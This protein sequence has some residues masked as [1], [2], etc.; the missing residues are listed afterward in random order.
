MSENGTR[1]LVLDVP[2]PETLSSNVQVFHYTKAKLIKQLRE[3]AVEV[4]VKSHAE[5]SIEAVKKRIKALD[6][7]NDWQTKKSALS[8]KL[9]KQGK[10]KDEIDAHLEEV[11]GDN[12]SYEAVNAIE[13]PFLYTKA[14]VRVL[15]GNTVKRD[16]D[17]PN[18]WPT[19]KAITDGLTDCAW[20]EDDNFNYLTEVS[21]A[22]GE[23]SDT[24]GCYRFQIII[25]PVLSDE[26]PA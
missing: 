19:V 5:D 11:I 13:V 24:K 16:F 10:T 18:F 25:E 3:T 26:L 2:R 4:G 9:K 8:K 20:W 21:F 17:P 23:R 22:Y 7:R 12:A 6:V 14:R 15:I 1:T